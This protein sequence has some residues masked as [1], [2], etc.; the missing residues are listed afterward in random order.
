MFIYIFENKVCS[1]GQRKKLGDIN[2]IFKIQECKIIR[3]H[4][5]TCINNV[6]YGNSKKKYPRL[7]RYT[8]MH[9]LIGR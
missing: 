5:N 9:K 6:N 3:R 7:Y 4:H 2:I 8:H 1:I